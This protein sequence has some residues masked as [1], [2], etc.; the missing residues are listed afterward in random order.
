MMVVNKLVSD[1]IS[2][3]RDQDE[4]PQYVVRGGAGGVRSFRDGTR[5]GPNGFG[6]SVQTAPGISEDAL[7]R[8]GS[9]PNAQVSVSTVRKLEAIPGVTVS[10]PTPGFGAYH[11][12]V[13]LPNPPPPG[14]FDAIRDAFTQKPNPYVIPR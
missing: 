14:L 4:S 3:G 11:G 13:N 7:T 5:V 12:T 2:A 9:F 8:G 6:F 10:T 1:A